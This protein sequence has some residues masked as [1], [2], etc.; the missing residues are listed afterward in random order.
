M[1]RIRIVGGTI[2]KTTGGDHNIYSDGNIVYNAGKA[3][4]ET[5]DKGIIYGEPKDAPPAP[6]LKKYFVDGWWSSDEAG[7]KRIKEALVGD[8]V[9]FHIKTKD[10]PNGGIVQ[11]K[12]YDDD[13]NEKNEPKEK[14]KK[15]QDDFKK[16]INTQ[17]NQE[18]A[19]G[20]VKDNK[21]V[22]SIMLENFESF[23]KDETDKQIELYYR[24]SYKNEHIEFPRSPSDY[25]RVRGMPKII[26]VNGQWRLAKYS[27]GENVG[28]TQ[29]KK[30]YWANGF[31]KS[32]R[33]YFDK[34]FSLESKQK[35]K[36]T[37]V[38]TDE[39][40]KQKF[41]LYY[42]GSSYAGGDQSGSDRFNNGKKFAEENYKEITQG[43]GNESV[44]IVSHSEG[45]A[46][47]AGMAEFLY[48]K[49]H[50]IGEHVLLSPDEGDEFE[51]NP[52]IPS[53]QLQ[54]MFF[55]S[56]YNPIMA[57]VK[58]FKF[59]KWGNYYAVVDWVTNEH[60]IKGVK[61]SGISLE[62]NAGWSGV[63]GWT[64]GTDVFKR[65]TDLKEVRSF[66]VIG[67]IE[68]KPY[69]GKDQTKTNKDTKFY[70]INNDYIITN[71]PPIIKIK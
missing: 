38:K 57:D 16:M 32:A 35:I 30:P 49:G 71:C 4:T 28:P 27:L 18:V 53:Y 47:A 17:T 60:S 1:S 44:Y 70:K 64:N 67:E 25:L 43:L 20:T 6:L 54:Y 63:H 33:T 23:I 3:I 13:N 56:I 29:P 10:I 46:Y 26:I 69:S 58:Y 68:G 34:Y 51:I 7:D 8:H 61:K 42:D 22:K 45:G 66:D 11:M 52:A 14:D 9:Y 40:E 62:Q 31:S 36:G 41:I 59:R 2:T 21:I 15:D 48:K 65:I 5:S 37:L 19:S 50:K 55:S 12:L 24:C 39:L